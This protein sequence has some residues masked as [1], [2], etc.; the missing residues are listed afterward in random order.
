MRLQVLAV[1]DRLQPAIRLH[2]VTSRGVDGG[3]WRYPHLGSLVSFDFL[4]CDLL[5]ANRRD[6]LQRRRWDALVPRTLHSLAIRRHFLAAYLQV[7][8][9]VYARRIS[10]RRVALARDACLLIVVVITVPIRVVL[11]A[12]FEVPNFRRHQV[13]ASKNKQP[14]TFPFPTRLDADLS[15]RPPCR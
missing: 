11:C 9:R 1:V 3:R 8:A 5:A 4:F 10:D 2:F 15:L 12:E 6:S 7:R 13:S 14:K